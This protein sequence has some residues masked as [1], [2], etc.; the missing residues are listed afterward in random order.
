MPIPGDQ[1][2]RERPHSIGN[3]LDRF[4]GTWSPE[5]EAELLDAVEV[6]EQVDESVWSLPPKQNRQPGC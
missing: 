1:T 2:D 3:A 4:I 6:F 5:E